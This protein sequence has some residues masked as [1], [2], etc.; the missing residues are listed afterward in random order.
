[1]LVD[2]NFW[3]DQ[4]FVIVLRSKCALNLTIQ[5]EHKVVFRSEQTNSIDFIAIFAK[6]FSANLRITGCLTQLTG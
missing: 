4:V 5:S 1:M 2:T 6:K 3:I